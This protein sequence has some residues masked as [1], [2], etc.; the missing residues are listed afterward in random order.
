[1]E[2]SLKPPQCAELIIARLSDGTALRPRDIWEPERIVAHTVHK[3]LLR[4][5]REGRVIREGAT[6]WH[7]YR[8]ADAAEE[9][10]VV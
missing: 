9:G 4:L 2:I 6:G 7:R 1:M 5:V 8:L 10:G 3:E